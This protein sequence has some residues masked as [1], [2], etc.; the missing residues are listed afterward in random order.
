MEYDFRLYA[1]SQPETPADSVKV[2][3]DLD[4]ASMVLR[5]LA[6][7]ALCGNIDMVKLSTI[8]F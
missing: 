3:R 7:G 5:E 2:R 6:D 4:S 1:A 8:C